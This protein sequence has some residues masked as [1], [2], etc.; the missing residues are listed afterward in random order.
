MYTIIILGEDV[1]FEGLPIITHKF[2]IENVFLEEVYK[3]KL[4]LSIVKTAKGS[5]NEWCCE[6]MIKILIFSQNNNFL[7]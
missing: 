6:I 5:E 3:R 7:L 1:L 2:V 4:S